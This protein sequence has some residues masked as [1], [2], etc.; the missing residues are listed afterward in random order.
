[1]YTNLYTLYTFKKIMT[2]NHIEQAAL[3][4]LKELGYEVLFGPDIGP[5]SAG[6]SGERERYQDV[7]L[8]GRLRAAVERLNPGL[9]EAAREEVVRKVV[10][11]S[12]PDAI[13][14]NRQ[15]HLLLVDGVDVE[16]RHEDGELGTEKARLIDATDI[17]SN[18]FIAVNQFTVVHGDYNRRPDVV[19][20]INGLPLVVLELKNAVDE[21]AT[22]E[23]A[24]NQL[25]TYKLQI[26]QLFRF[27][28]LLVIT[29]GIDAEV[30]TLTSGRDRFTAWKTIDGEKEL[31]GVPM[32]EVLLRGL[33]TPKH[34]VDVVRNFIVF[35]KT[36]EQ[37]YIKK[38]A[39]YHQY[40]AV[41]RALASTLV[42]ITEKHD[43]KAGVV[44]HTQGSGKSLSMVFYTGKVVGNA[45]LQNPT[46]VVLTDRNDLDD[47]LFETFGNCIDL[48]RQTPAQATTRKE[49]RELLAR[50]S[51]GVI[52]A[53]IQKFTP[54][55][56]EDMMPL[57]S[58]RE[59]IIVMADEAHRSQYGL[60]ARIE[61]KGGEAHTVYGYAK[62]LR[63]AIPNASYIGFTGTPIDA[64]DHSTRAVFG[65]YVD[66]Y[67]IERA[68]KDR[69]TVPLYYESRLVDLAINQ[70]MKAQIDTDFETLTEGEELSQRDELAAKWTQLEAIVGNEKR[71]AH[72]ARDIVEH[73]ESRLEALDGKGMIV[74]MSRR[75]CVELYNAIIALRPQWHSDDDTQGFLKVIMTGSAS[76]P[77]T[78]QQHIRTK[79][80]RKALAKFVRKADTPVK[81]V[82]V[83]DMWLTGF[84]APSMHTMYLDKPMKGHNLM[85]AIARVN[86]VFGDKPGGLVVD[87]LGVAGALR[88]ALQ[89]YTQSG[90]EGKP[91]FDIA[92]AIAAMKEKL[93]I[94]RALFHGFEY[95]TYFGLGASEQMQMILD[96]EEHILS[97]E[98]GEKRLAQYVTELGK[99]FA[100]AMPSAEAIAIREEIAFF[101]AIKA[102]LAKVTGKTMSDKDYENAIRQIVD[103]AIAP[104]GIVD[105]FAAAGLEKPEL[106]LLSDE[107][108][109]EI[110][111][112]KRKHLALEA[113]KQI[114]NDEIQVKFSSNV[115][116]QRRFSELLMQAL[117]KYKNKS[118]EAAQV[119]EELIAIAKEMKVDAAQDAALGMTSDE[120]AFYDA[121]VMN[122]SAREVLG[123]D[124]LRDLARVL[125]KRV[126]NTITIDWSIRDSAR[127]RLRVEVKKL[128][129]EYGYPPD[130][131][132]I[133]TELVL[134]QTERFVE[135]GEK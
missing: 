17:L 132:K 28:E 6:G 68:V 75:I 47:Q 59:N 101:Q 89:T 100:L 38:V 67:D 119:I 33:C 9:P 80:K 66:I 84:D 134:E 53:T 73:F 109:A 70:D 69:A 35:E 50:E 113:L 63:D 43:G 114:L 93:E 88:D 85:Q 44:W 23:N 46:I 121:L 55:E 106:D 95:R 60:T 77:A 130:A 91:T 2:E 11:E 104:A 83:R 16:Y 36:V 15:F 20:F 128:L 56:D 92:E 94:V 40:W 8:V 5:V 96:A 31:K 18:D 64:T 22:L 54:G 49:L 39:A 41:N 90:G 30:G 125:V 115:V 32:L 26:P 116:K 103:K 97:K 7:V 3:E 135:N 122:D 107:F 123:D 65:D 61:T 34:I 98:D 21:R 133:A 102:R 51:G 120:V 58:A 14:D 82:I 19:L 42:A 117:K 86:R 37:S 76:D 127:A 124:K 108:M 71:V 118:I 131:E 129:R 72:I 112:M 81:L 12:T 57:L 27:N 79:E 48:L 62:H 99:A 126:R 29:D 1:M 24:Y 45:Q 25:Q 10:R 78:W 111:G 52:F 105:L 110:R 74:C 13:F 87:Y 4:I